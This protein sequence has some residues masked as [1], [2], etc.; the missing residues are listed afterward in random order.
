MNEE[1]IKNIINQHL[2]VS[3]NF[4][5]LCPQILEITKVITLSLKKNGKVILFGNGGSAG[6]AQHIAAELSGKFYNQERPGLAA[7]SLTTNT[8]SI[9]AIGNDFGYNEIFSRQLEGFADKGDVVIGITTSGTSSNVI[10]GISKANSLGCKSITFTGISEGPLDAISDYI[11]KI[12]SDD[13]PRIQEHHILLG[14]IICEL[15]ENEIFGGN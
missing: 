14:H 5:E 7:I 3:S 12:P 11:I 1:K 4:V 15:V 10:K 9:T 8:S 2:A 13:T 6:D